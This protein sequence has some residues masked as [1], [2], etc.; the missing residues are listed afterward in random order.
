M[1]IKR[2]LLE[3]IG[4]SDYWNTLA[5]FLH[6][7]C[8]KQAFDEA[9]HSFLRT[10]EAK[11]LHN[12]LIRSIIYNAHF[13]MSPPDDLPAP[14]PERPLHIRRA[15]AVT[16]SG[17]SFA[18]Y[19][20]L[21]LRH[22]PSINQL[23]ERITILIESRKIRVDSKATG[24]LFAQLR[25]FVTRLLE[26]TVVLLSL[27]GSGEKKETKIMTAQLIHVLSA[28]ADLASIVS[29][30]ILTKYSNFVS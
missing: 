16:P 3:V 12:D 26:N 20:A 4:E 30:A 14:R 7:Q 15:V 28:H 19:T 13:A 18:T 17:P 2:K 5:S 11:I 23:S 29:P 27:R 10:P 22:L 25:R 24:V 9:M 21:D 6:G 8:S 1:A